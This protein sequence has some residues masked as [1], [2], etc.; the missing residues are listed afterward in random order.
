[1]KK[2]TDT[3]SLVKVDYKPKKKKKRRSLVIHY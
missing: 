1:M 3:N 2:A